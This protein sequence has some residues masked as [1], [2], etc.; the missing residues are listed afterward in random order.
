VTVSVRAVFWKVALPAATLGPVGFYLAHR[1][2]PGALLGLGLVWPAAVG[3]IGWLV[4]LRAFRRGD[5]V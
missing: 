2:G 1:V 4:A 5:A 3:T